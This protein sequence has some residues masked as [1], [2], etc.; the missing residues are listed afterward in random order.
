MEVVCTSLATKIQL[1]FLKFGPYSVVFLIYTESGCFCT[2][3]FVLFIL[4]VT[5]KHTAGPD[6]GVWGVPA[7]CLVLWGLCSVDWFTAA[8]FNPALATGS[9]VFQT[10]YW[11][12]G[13][14]PSN[15]LTH[16]A[17]MYI[18]GASLGGLCA[19]LYYNMHEKLFLNER[20]DV[21]DADGVIPSVNPD[22]LY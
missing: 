6:L 9:T 13:I 19:G 14:N 2:F 15:V 12:E 11:T 20:D 21:S 22:K 18:G 8:S 3:V 16:Y 4:H 7:I 5:G 17:P 1:L 10:L